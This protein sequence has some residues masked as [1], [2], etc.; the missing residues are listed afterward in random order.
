MEGIVVGTRGIYHI[1]KEDCDKWGGN[2]VFGTTVP[3]CLLA[4]AVV[5]CSMPLENMVNLKVFTD[6]DADIW[7]TSCNIGDGPGMFEPRA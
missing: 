5:V 6:A 2:H 4:P 1:R 7:V 3:E